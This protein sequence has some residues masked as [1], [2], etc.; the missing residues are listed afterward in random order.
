MFLCSVLGLG[1]ILVLS[2]ACFITFLC[3]YSAA[4]NNS[5]NVLFIVCAANHQHVKIVDTFQ[6]EIRI[7]NVCN[8]NSNFKI[9]VRKFEL[10]FTSLGGNVISAHL[11]TFA[12]AALLIFIRSTTLQPAADWRVFTTLSVPITTRE[13][14]RRSTWPTTL[15]WTTAFCGTLTAAGPFTSLTNLTRASVVFFIQM[16]LRLSSILKSYP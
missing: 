1:R 11:V 4:K 3:S 12:A 8:S 16:G 2:F 13:I 14:V 5:I 7:P 10:R 6:S 9:E 15:C